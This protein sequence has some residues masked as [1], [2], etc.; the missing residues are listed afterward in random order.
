MSVGLGR[1]DP[2]SRDYYSDASLQGSKSL[3]RPFD[4]ID[5]VNLALP[6]LIFGALAAFA[7]A[8]RYPVFAFASLAIGV[9]VTLFLTHR[10]F[11]KRAY[12][13]GTPGY[14][15]ANLGWTRA[16]GGVQ[17]ADQ[18]RELHRAARRQPANSDKVSDKHEDKLIPP[19]FFE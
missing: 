7:L 3:D 8:L 4:W 2:L 1:K 12:A 15:K 18:I 13:E 14:E 19:F 10:A 17:T 11:C 6:V 9:S 5:L 16:R